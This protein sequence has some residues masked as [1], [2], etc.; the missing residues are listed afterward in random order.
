MD[1]SLN[2]SIIVAI[3]ENGVIGVGG[4][5][6]WNL[7]TDL[8]R[9]AK[10]TKG[11]VVIVG[12]KTYD[13]ILKRLGHSLTDR[14]TLVLTRQK[15][16]AVNGN[17]V[18]PIVSWEETLSSAKFLA[19]IDEVFVIGGAEIY[20]LALPY[21][22][23]IYLTCV[24]TIIAGDT[25]FPKINLDEW[26]E[27]SREFH[28]ADKKNSHPFSFITMKRKEKSWQ[29]VNLEY[30]RHEDQRAVM[31]RIHQQGFCPFCPKHRTSGEVLKPL[32]R[33]KHWILVPN[34]WPYKST[35][36]HAILITERHIRFFDE[37]RHEE[38]AELVELLS[39]ARKTYNLTAYSLGVRAGDLHLTGGTVDHLHIH[40]IVANPETDKLGYERVR[41]PMG[42]K[43]TGS[44]D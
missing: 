9:F 34:R 6:P 7:K 33:G 31:E 24:E 44:I 30:A 20:K 36:L 4:E 13:S 12:R 8:K 16:L 35:S 25:F 32:H 27:V 40:L 43:P 28:P 41:F 17:D 5:L 39:W 26:K 1:S 37:L 14:I 15:D 23:T 18:I 29:F 3:S 10:R 22:N 19:L 42:P 11:H 21:A 38:V 2:L